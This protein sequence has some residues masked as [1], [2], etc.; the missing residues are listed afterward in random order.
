MGV[1]IF[2]P[3]NTLI[4]ESIKCY[5]YT[6]PGM[7]KST[8][9]HTADK[10]VIFDFD[11]GQHRVSAELRR[12]TIV[13]IDSWLDLE[14][15]K[16]DF[17]SSFKTIVADT[18]GAMLDAIK[19]HL[20]KNTD[21]LQRDK[22]L[23]LK[24]QGLAGNL[25]LKMVRKWE[26]LGKDIV[27]IAH[28]VEQESGKDKTKIVR[29]DLAGKNSSMLYRMSDIMGYLHAS[30]DENGDDLRTIYFNPS[31]SHHGKN[32]GR[33]G[34]IH[35]NEDGAEICT[36][37]VNVPELSASPTF[38][39]DLLKQAKD[40]INTLTPLQVEELKNIADLNHCKQVCTEANHAGDLNQLTE[41]LVQEHKYVNEMWR[42]IKA[43]G[44]EMN[45]QFNAETKRWYNPP[46]FKGITEAQRDE[47]QELLN[48]VEMDV[49]V[50]CEDQGIDSLLGIEA[51][52][53]ENVK[54]HIINTTQG[55]GRAIA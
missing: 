38:L 48:E 5:L 44:K 20:A 1:H 23:T 53:F 24:A 13:R 19:D 16:D 34:R 27:F 21:N 33:L 22:S 6:D 49:A 37:Q 50:F 18:V 8:I 51:Q 43:R 47:L 45:C 55:Q 26:N 15:L 35:K 28:A 32:S 2:T 52:H 46:A 17:Y 54:A 30:T 40:H 14:N 12:G 31:N 29:P 7:G 36:G 10:P 39:A 9:A 4:V 41:S 25:F 3:E 11:K 42:A